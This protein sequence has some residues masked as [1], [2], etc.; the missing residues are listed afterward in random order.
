MLNGDFVAKI[1]PKISVVSD[2]GPIIHLDELGCLHLM[3]DF[4]KV[5][6]PDGVRREVLEHRSIAF[7]EEDVRRPWDAGKKVKNFPSG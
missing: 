3:K 5:L 7:Q 2:A 4:D 6:V 1:R